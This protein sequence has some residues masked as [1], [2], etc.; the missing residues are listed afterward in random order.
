MKN[1]DI[2]NRKILNPKS[3]SAMLSLWRFQQKKIVF[4]NGCFD[5]LHPGHIDYL[6][7]AKD[8]GDVLV[9]GVNTDRS[10]QMLDKGA[11]RP[12]TNENARALILAALHFV[13]AVILF[14]E[15]TP[16]ELIKTVQPDILVKGSDYLAEDIVGYDVVKAKGGKVITIDFLPGYSTTGIIRKIKSEK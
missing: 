9:V 1:L 16:Y 3:L 13:D 14:D 4:T 2:I 6:S 7:K 15:E 11:N 12:V 10:V 8:E 5:L